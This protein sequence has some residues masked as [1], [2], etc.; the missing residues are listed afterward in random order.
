MFSLRWALSSVRACVSSTFRARHD[1][2]SVR[3]GI[4]LCLSV[5]VL[6]AAFQSTGA[7]AEDVVV[8]RH[9]TIREAPNRHS[10]AVRYPAVGESLTLLDSGAR[11]HGY[12]H[13][14]LSNGRTG[15]VYY[16]F[17]SRPEQPAGAAPAAAGDVAIVHFIDMDQGN[18]AL[19]EF[20]CGAILIDAGGRTAADGDHLIAYL[21]A[22][23]AR[24]TDLN[25]HLAA[26][27]I[28]HT[29]IDHNRALKR[30]AETFLVDGYVHNGRLIGSGRPNAVWMA[31]FVSIHVPAIPA[32]AVDDAALAAGGPEGLT[33]PVVDPLAC[34]R[35]DPD[36]RVLSGGYRDNP[37]WPDGEFDNGNNHSLVIRVTYGQAKFLFTGDLEEPAIETLL[38]R[39]FDHELLNVDVYAV[40]HHG[41]ANG[42]TPAL[43]SV[44]S[45]QVA[46][47]SMGNS[48]TQDQWTA[49]AYGHPRRAIV[50]M[51]ERSVSRVRITPVQVLV[52]DS[53]KHFSSFMLTKAVYGTGWNGD[54]DIS[55]RPDGV[56][57]V[58]TAK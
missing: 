25:R 41:S 43:L 11:S 31:N 9:V 2:W 22:F 50:S 27:F 19:L 5:L 20:P 14:R 42:T 37:G 54:I 28:T 49:W 15:W 23:F 38:A 40:G 26:I 3:P 47:I 32:V 6:S 46:V 21:N 48:S 52:A 16:T 12:Y 30:V 58:E 39:P 51:L 4:R 13:V 1:R 10:D 7:L 24:R 18:A 36:I 17:V 8:K 29:H 33:G 34:A 35:V 57:T 55:A 44:M 45:P 56:L 53:V